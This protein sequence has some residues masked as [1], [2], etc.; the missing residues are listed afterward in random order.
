MCFIK[1]WL[2]VVEFERAGKEKRARR[3]RTRPEPTIFG[4]CDSWS[5]IV[6]KKAAVGDRKIFMLDPLQPNNRILSTTYQHAADPYLDKL[7]VNCERSKTSHDLS[8]IVDS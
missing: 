5:F 3:V 6:G 4:N 1:D 8:H 7:C 2:Q